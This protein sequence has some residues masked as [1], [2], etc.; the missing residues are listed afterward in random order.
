MSERVWIVTDFDPDNALRVVAAYPTEPL[1]KEHVALM[2]GYIDE[3][4]VRS[5][6]HADA[7]DPVKNRNG[8]QNKTQPG[9]HTLLTKA[10]SRMSVWLR[11]SISR[12]VCNP[13]SRRST[14]AD[15]H[16]GPGQ[17]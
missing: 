12:G 14:T 7:T 10:L 3:Q 1:A 11:K 2:G 17:M 9:K 15:A 13:R 5:A 8:R 4:E 16:N 6:L